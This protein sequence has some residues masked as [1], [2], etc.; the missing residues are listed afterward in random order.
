[1]ALKYEPDTTWLRE[2][3][4]QLVQ[5]ALADLKRAY[6]NFFERRATYPK[7]KHKKT[8][9]LRF[10]IPQRV[11]LSDGYVTVPK[12]GRVKVRQSQEVEG[13]TKSATFTRDACGHWFVSL[14]AEIE[15]PVVVLPAPTEERTI[16]I[17]LGL[18]DAIV[19]S[20]GE[21]VA[22]PQ[23]YRRGQRKLRRAQR[24]TS[25]KKKG[26]KNRAKARLHVARVHQKIAAKRNDFCHKLTTRLIKGHEAVCIENLTVKGLVK[27]KLAKSM[28]D[29]S[30]GTIRRQLAYKGEWYRTH[31]VAV[32]RFYPSSKLCF[33]CAYKNEALTLSDRVWMCPSC[34]E[35]LDRD[36][37]AAK[38]IKREGLRLLAETVAEGRPE[39]LNACG[40][41]VRPAMPA[42]LAL[43]A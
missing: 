25:R 43:P 37:N 35:M 15:M 32:G 1:T 27:T 20:D 4:S 41:D 33:E 22:A 9:R 31:V 23:C 30:M 13:T 28:L 7:V 12:I 3:D 34:R 42:D 40:Q 39:T 18:K 16:G 10:R 24:S 17:D 26:S 29:A 11:T 6:T 2:I 5:Q 19:T 14:V 8:D 21:R 38:N 36:L